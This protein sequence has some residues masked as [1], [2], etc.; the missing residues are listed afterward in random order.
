M[1]YGATEGP[2]PAR[3]PTRGRIHPMADPSHH[4]GQPD[5]RG[6][7]RYIWW[8]IVSQRRRVLTGSLLGSAWMVGLMVPPYLLSRAIDDG[9]T[10]GDSA[11]LLGWTGALFGVGVLNAWLA[12]MR[13]RVMTRVR[14]DAAFRSV[15]V[16]TEHTTRLGDVLARRTS[17]SEIL[18]IGLG[19][20]AQTANV[21]TITGPGVGAVLAYVVAALLLLSVSAPLAVVV[22]LGVP[23]LAVLIGPL[24]GRLQRVETVYRD[25]YGLL[26]TRLV[27]LIEGLR[28]LGGL[29]G[30]EAYAERYRDR[31]RA[32]RAEGY[33]VGTVTSWI[34]ALAVGLPTV[35]LAAVTW[36]AA[37][38]A[39]EGALT[40][41]QLVSVYGYAAV[42][43][44]P[45]AFFIEGGYDL[46]RGRVAARRII[47]FLALEPRS[48]D[49]S[50]GLDAP[51]GPAVLH[52]PDS[53]VDV[54]PGRFTAL[55]GARP[56][57]AALVVDRLGRFVDS[58]AVWGGVPLRDIAL[59]Q[60][61]SRLL[62]A[63]N[64]AALFAGTLRDAIV[65]RTEHSAD[66]LAR[67]VDAAMAQDIVH[68]LPDGLDSAVAAQGRDLSGGQ[69]Q[70]VRLARALLAAPEVL[71]AVEP[72][73]AVD[74]H[75]EAAMTARLAAHR[76]GLTTVVTS[77][78]PLVLD[79]AD[80][81][82]YLVGGRVVATGTHRE[83]LA[84]EPGYRRLV[85]RD[86]DDEQD[87]YDERDEQHE[88]G[89]GR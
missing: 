87:A 85:A 83:L 45:V 43:V 28:V 56:R 55:A 64:E 44:V 84:V 80:T 38:L 21:L 11:A 63:D 75:T 37:R 71:L 81:V 26:T 62:V 54:L 65:C 12:V 16:V 2:I 51:D 89:D 78:S 34:Q 40:T 79:R 57:E 66:E 53:G 35:F 48:D 39:A 10:P 69:R 1:P 67:A 72:T 23:V 20:V 27:D 30:K 52:D 86:T 25:E 3:T 50:A 22:L 9:L 18:T 58:E 17:S 46:S 76:A 15:R 29:G 14:M 82:C 41:G 88:G 24:L 5:L 32:L 31:S 6:P 73:S 59:T 70:R 42:L 7:F 33:R 74:A 60:V 61:R 77:T 13:H 8:L 4:P 36:P 49:P 68:G 19:D 47:D